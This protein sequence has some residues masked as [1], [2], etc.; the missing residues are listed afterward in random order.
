MNFKSVR[1]IL[2]RILILESIIM[3]P[4]FI[5]SLIYQESLI[6]VLSFIIT[7]VVCALTGFLIS[8]NTRKEMELG[9][10]EGLF[11]VGLAWILFSAFGA[12]PYVISSTIPNY[13]D[14]FFEACSGF[15]TTGAT[16]LKNFDTIAKSMFFYRASTQ[17]I[18]GMG[19]LV[20]ILSIMNDKKEKNSIHL[21]KAES[22]GPNVGKLTGKMKNTTRILYLLYIG[23]T[24][25]ETILLVF[26]KDVD[27][28]TALCIS[29]ATT[30]TGGFA[31]LST[32]IATYSIYVQYVIAIMMLLSGINFS[33]YYL[34][35]VRKF[36]QVIENEELRTYLIIIFTSLI[37]ITINTLPLYSNFEETFR[38]AFFNIV[39][40]ITTTGFVIGD[41]TSIYPVLSQFILAILMFIGGCA[42]STAGG[43][44][45]S[46]LLIVSKDGYNSFTSKNTPNKVDMVK[47]DGKSIENKILKETKNYLF[48]YITILLMV[49]FVAAIDPAAKDLTTA[50][51]SS[52][53]CLSNV[54]PTIGSVI[55]SSGDFSSYNL[56]TKI[57]F[58][59]EMLIG[60]LELFPIL[61]IF[62]PK[63]YKRF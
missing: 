63:A 42:G 57:F 58:S 28:Y 32:S 9:S 49:T 4:S 56:I 61:I 8:I 44:K 38:N 35:I 16:V 23:L 48:L 21:L 7:S 20:F 22:T 53:S 45:I 1:S 18:G 11:A 46:R 6:N 25:L 59:L 47:I 12:L 5:V 27:L 19:V 54:G 29:M 41:F 62:T 2:S 36:K 31:I 3:I 24:L 51:S 14:A 13:I 15:S 52:L 33:L 60:R 30:S 17:F 39:S 55:G 26:S 34:L 50:F 37:I 10:K 43:F 40:I